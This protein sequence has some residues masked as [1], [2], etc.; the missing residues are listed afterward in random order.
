M[1]PRQYVDLKEGGRNLQPTYYFMINCLLYSRMETGLVSNQDY[2]DEDVN[3]YLAHLLHS[4]INPDY[5]EQSKR[6]LSK[7]DADVFKRL[8]QSTDARLKY[9]IYKTNADFLLVSIGIFDNPLAPTATPARSKPAPSEEAY[10]GRGKTYYHFAYTYSNARV[11]DDYSYEGGNLYQFDFAT[12]WSFPML[13]SPVVARH[14]LVTT[15]SI[16][17]PWG[18]T[19]S[20]KLTLATPIGAVFS[21]GCGT[22][23]D[24]NNGDTNPKNWN[25]WLAAGAGR[26]S[27]TLGE[28]NLDIAITENFHVSE[29]TKAYLRLDILNVTNTAIWDP[30]AEIASWTYGQSP[31]VRYNKDGGPI[32]GV[33]RTLKVTA[34]FSW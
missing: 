8:S 20:G 24:C 28:R 18:L 25:N 19:F 3:V 31:S 29:L 16:D 23:L 32:L 9:A 33:P 6:Y 14:R 1:N 21:T 27:G 7:Y 22:V 2:Y 11:S 34:G 4:F 12:P 30:G 26:P 10:I 17:G 15:G 13:S 5:V